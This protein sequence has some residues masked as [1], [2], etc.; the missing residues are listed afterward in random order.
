MRQ[1]F[2]FC[3]QWGKEALSRVFRKKVWSQSQILCNP[4]QGAN[5]AKIIC[6]GSRLVRLRP[7]QQHTRLLQLLSLV[8]AKLIILS[9]ENPILPK[10]SYPV[11]ALIQPRSFRPIYTNGEAIQL[12]WRIHFLEKPCS[13][14]RTGHLDMLSNIGNQFPVFPNFAGIGMRFLKRHKNGLRRHEPNR[15]F[16][17]EIELGRL[18]SSSAVKAF[19]PQGSSQLITRRALSIGNSVVPSDAP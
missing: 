7:C 5:R 2:S 19:T 10:H 1:S 14:C 9:L 17:S 15:S 6:G 13:S 8:F 16:V 18:T 3:L 12:N 11:L 4:I